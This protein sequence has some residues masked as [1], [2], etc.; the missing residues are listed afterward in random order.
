MAKFPPDFTQ[1]RANARLHVFEL[2]TGSP[3]A[4]APSPTLERAW[5]DL[6]ARTNIRVS[7]EELEQRNQTSVPMPDG[8]GYLAW[9]EAFHQLHCVV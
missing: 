8:Q 7:R 2:A 5:T 3:Y 4:G 1:Q 6:L 9:L